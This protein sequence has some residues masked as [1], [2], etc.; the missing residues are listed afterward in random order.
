M[1]CRGF[2]IGASD[3]P[4][5]DRPTDRRPPRPFGARSLP[6]AAVRV[7]DRECPTPLGAGRARAGPSP[8]VSSRAARDPRQDERPCSRSPSRLTSRRRRTRG[9]CGG[10]SGSFAAASA[11][12]P[13]S[14]TG[15]VAATCSPTSPPAGPSRASCPTPTSRSSPAHPR[16][17]APCTRTPRRSRWA[18]TDDAPRRRRPRHVAPRARPQRSGAGDRHVAGPA[19]RLHGP[20]DGPGTL[21]WGQR[22]RAGERMIGA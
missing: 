1:A 7:P 8:S 15:A 3:V 5:S 22:G 12:A 19:A 6:T 18:C 14:T 9:S 20:L 21:A 17:A 10:G 4:P 13:T 11:R 2:R 16:R